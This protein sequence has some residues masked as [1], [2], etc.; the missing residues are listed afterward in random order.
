MK[1]FIAIVAA[2]GLVAGG[3]VLLAKDRSL[4]DDRAVVDDAIK[5]MSAEDLT[6]EPAPDVEHG[7][8]PLTKDVALL[9]VEDLKDIEGNGGLLAIA[10]KHGASM[11]QVRV[12]QKAVDARLHAVT[13]D[14]HQVVEPK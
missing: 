12:V 1:A 2:A 4:T 7:P 14:D 8:P 9:I 13:P 11:A 5:D 10:R 3:A 6:A